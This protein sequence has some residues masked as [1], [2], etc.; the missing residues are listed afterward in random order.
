[1]RPSPQKHVLVHKISLF[2]FF[3]F[4]FWKKIS[5]YTWWWW[6]KLPIEVFLAFWPF[7]NERKCRRNC[8]NATKIWNLAKSEYQQRLV[9]FLLNP[10][11]YKRIIII[12]V[13][14]WITNFPLLIPTLSSSCEFYFFLIQTVP[15]ICFMTN[16]SP[17]RK[18]SLF[19][20]LRNYNFI[21]N[22]IASV[23]WHCV[24]KS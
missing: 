17:M 3:F 10:E 2:F 21:V 12:Q 7:E 6:K 24:Y 8:K 1:M 13:S 18:L 9:H 5:S 22:A 19:R 15:F 4:F 16:L 14:T 20:A 11:T 23:K